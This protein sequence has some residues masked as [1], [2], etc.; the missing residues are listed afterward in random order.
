MSFHKRQ[1]DFITHVPGYQIPK[2]NKSY[3]FLHVSCTAAQSLRLSRDGEKRI[4]NKIIHVKDR[5]L[6]SANSSIRGPA[7][8]F[9]R[10][11]FMPYDQIL[12]ATSDNL[13]RG[14]S[15]DITLDRLIKR[16]PT[17]W[18]VERLVTS[19]PPVQRRMFLDFRPE[20]IQIPLWS[21]LSVPRRCNGLTS[22]TDQCE[23]TLGWVPSVTPPKPTTLRN[24]G[25]GKR[26]REMACHW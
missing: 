8:G 2:S 1:S 13:S 26:R 7:S 22:D 18:S 9:R 25:Q 10:V 14:G 12:G 21:I 3:W 6:F 24:W 23:Q 16:R 11:F 4:N 5:V 17:C 20:A 19:L 15:F